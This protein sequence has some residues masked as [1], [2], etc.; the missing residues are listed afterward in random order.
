MGH[1]PLSLRKHHRINS[2]AMLVLESWRCRCFYP[3]TWGLG[4]SGKTQPSVTSVEEK[5]PSFFAWQRETLPYQYYDDTTT[6]I[7]FTSSVKD[8]RWI[9]NF[10]VFRSILLLFFRFDSNHIF[11]LFPSF[12]VDLLRLRERIQ[13][14]TQILYPAY[15]VNSCFATASTLSTFPY[16][17]FF[18][19][20]LLRKWMH[21][22]KESQNKETQNFPLSYIHKQKI[23]SEKFS[24]QIRKKTHQI[25]EVEISI[26]EIFLRMLLLRSLFFAVGFVE[27]GRCKKVHLDIIIVSSK[28]CLL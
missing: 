11:F 5:I 27:D 2:I 25:I 9:H 12:F 20:T 18:S 1:Q 24:F 23:A 10:I 6:F 3:T 7:W 26:Q 17:I 16:R 19:R 14:E 28:P 4:I 8:K 21:S 15:I 13:F 22:C